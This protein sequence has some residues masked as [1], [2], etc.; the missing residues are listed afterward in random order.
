MAKDVIIALDFDSMEKALNFVD[1][2]SEKLYVKVGME[3]FYKEGPK[4][5][6]EIKKRG[7]KIFLDLKL[8][9]IPNTVAKATIS[10]L[11]LNTDMINY[12]IAGGGEMLRC[13]SQE[14]RKIN[15]NVITLGITMLT[16]TSEDLMHNDIL[17]DE[18]YSLKETVL[19]YANLAKNS[20]LSGVVCSALEVKDI[21]EKLGKD[22]L[23]ITPGIR[24]ASIDGDDQ[25]RVV[26][27]K[28]AKE[29]G[30]DYIVVGRPIIK[31]ENPVQVY[32]EIKEMFLGD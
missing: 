17:I 14:A 12:Q 30:S 8:H 24:L 18:K 11:S 13:A 1:Q 20:G 28:D 5:I 15:E 2:F 32:K 19:N 22:F 3:L 25:K 27:P 23:C 29:Y 9:D 10:L 21:K 26:T 4:V 7:H 16:S 6:E 31:A